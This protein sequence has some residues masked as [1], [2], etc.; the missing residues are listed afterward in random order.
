MATPK[1]ASPIMKPPFSIPCYPKEI[2]LWWRTKTVEKWPKASNPRILSLLRDE[3]TVQSDRFNKERKFDPMSYGSRDL[4][5]LT[6]GSFFFPRTW[7]QST[8]VMAETIDLR[9]WEAPRKGPLRILDLGSGSGSG[10]LAALRL[11]RQRGVANPIELRAVD[12]SVKSLAHLR[13]IHADLSHLWPDTAVKTDITDLSQTLLGKPLHAYDFI[14]F[15]S[16][17]NEIIGGADAQKVAERLAEISR[18][19]KPGGFLMV[20]E[21]ALKTIC[22]KLHQAAAILVKDGDL[23]LH[24]PYFNGA[25]CPFAS[26]PSRYHSH[27][28]RRRAP[29]ASVQQ[30]NEPLRLAVRDVKFGFVLLSR[31]K[32]VPF[33]EGPS[34]LRL[35]SPLI[36]RKGVHYFVGVGGDAEERSYEIQ[37]RDLTI[38]GRRF[39]K[40]L[41]R[42]DVLRLKEW[43]S[44]EKGRRIRIPNADAVEVLWHPR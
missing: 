27:E 29:P 20:V 3:I 31:K 13:S 18:L 4:S 40:R 9:G 12:Y 33:D 28:V 41:E 11:L 38:E 10:G 21:P 5:I 44:F 16:S 2:E 25:S 6:Y 36:K 22:K 15:N 35:V 19:L 37:N 14:L 43:K 30:L 26:S 1:S 32:P 23:Q 34:V 24:G 8:F 17:L 39:I 42:G 7:M